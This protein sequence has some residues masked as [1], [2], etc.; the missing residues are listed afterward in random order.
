MFTGIVE[1]IGTIINMQ[2]RNDMTLW[3]GTKGKGTELTVRGDVAMEG[4]YLG[5]VFNPRP[6]LPA[7]NFNFQTHVSILVILLLQ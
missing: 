7:S 5:W 1:E 4:A 3:D 2:E 6:R